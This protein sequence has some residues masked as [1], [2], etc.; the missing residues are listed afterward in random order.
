MYYEDAGQKQHQFTLRRFYILNTS[1][2]KRTSGLAYNGNLDLSAADCVIGILSR[3]GASEN[4]F[5]HIEA[6]HPFNY[7][8]G[9]KLL[10]S[11]RQEI[12]NPELKNVEKEIKAYSKEYDKACKKLAKK[13]KQIN[14]D[15]SV[16]SNDAYSQLKKRAGSLEEK[17]EEL[18]AYKQKLPE[19]VKVNEI[20]SSKDYKRHENEGK[21]LFDFTTSLVWNARKIGQSILEEYYPYKNDVVDLF[22]AITNA[23]G[24]VRIDEKEVRVVLEPLEQR[25]R[26]NAQ[27][28]FCKRLN[29]LGAETPVGKKI[30][31]HVDSY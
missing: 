27:I 1:S 21:N 5:K 13:D 24:K 25:S 14:G 22:Y 10:K 20:D 18:T 2:K 9:F 15:G 23:Q 17:I 30:S 26:R 11:N 6:R 31:I 19:R 12:K 7:R 4:T 16:R 8:P 29:Q 3:W 28:E